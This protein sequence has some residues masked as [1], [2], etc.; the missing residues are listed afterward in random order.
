M[1]ISHS[2][3]PNIQVSLAWEKVRV[4][5]LSG[6]H[7]AKAGVKQKASQSI[8]TH[9][10]PNGHKMLT[11]QACCCPMCQARPQVLGTQYKGKQDVLTM[12]Y[13]LGANNERSGLLPACSLE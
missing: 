3:T 6:A 10:S 13:R 9:S 4:F 11:Q 2:V 12:R 5:R 1:N 8:P 7:L